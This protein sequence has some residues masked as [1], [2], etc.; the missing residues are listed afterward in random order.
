MPLFL[1]WYI[2][3]VTKSTLTYKLRNISKKEMIFVAA[4]P[5]F[6]SSYVDI[7]DYSEKPV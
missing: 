1:V 7:F 3:K 4:Q 2:Y 5:A 6:D